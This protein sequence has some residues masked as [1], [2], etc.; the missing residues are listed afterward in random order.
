ME[1]RKMHVLN[2]KTKAA[3]SILLILTFAAS[4]I[5]LFEPISAQAA[6]TL[7]SYPIIDAIPN[8]VGVGEQVLIRTGILMQLGSLQDG[9][10]NI[11]VSV[12]KPDNTTQILGPFRTDSTGS[13]FTIFVPDQV[14]TYK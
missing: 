5:I 2:E 9:W 4:S 3:I 14:G 1:E 6:P 13:T 7:R 12:V 11:I 8:P 10:N